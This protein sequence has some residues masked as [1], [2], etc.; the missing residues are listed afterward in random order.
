MGKC[1]TVVAL[2][3][4]LSSSTFSRDDGRYA[5]EPPNAA[6]T[7]PPPASAGSSAGT[8]PW[9]TAAA[10]TGPDRQVQVPAGSTMLNAGEVL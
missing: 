2:L 1:A 9:R 5:N 3:V 6:A 4:G 8:A 10:S 7:P